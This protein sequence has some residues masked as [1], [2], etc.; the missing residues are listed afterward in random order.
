[1]EK[2]RESEGSPVAGVFM[3]KTGLQ[4]GAVALGYDVG[5]TLAVL[6]EGSS[7][8]SF[9]ITFLRYDPVREK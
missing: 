8:P 6:S 7:P 1:M 2:V 4:I 9:N 5:I 3:T